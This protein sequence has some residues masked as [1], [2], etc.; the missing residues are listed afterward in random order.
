[1]RFVRSFVLAL[2]F[3]AV[4]A[5]GPAAAAAYRLGLGAN[6]WF[7]K[8]GIFDL[9][10]AVTTPV[11]RSVSVGARLGAALVTS[12]STAA[13]PLDLVLRGAF[14]RA[15]VEG[16]AGPWIFFEGDAVR[17]HAGMGFGLRA[18]DISAGIEIAYLDPDA[19]LGFKLSF[20]L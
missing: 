20:A 4:L 18:R 14:R 16:V 6:Y 3:V 10:L 17:A 7:A 12:P 5:P 9:T 19:I 8:S 2:A 15:Y 13:L 11:A 1:M